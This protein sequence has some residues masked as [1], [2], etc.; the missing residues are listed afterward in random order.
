MFT[1][2]AVVHASQ[3]MTSLTLN[4]NT[5][6]SPNQNLIHQSQQQL[7]KQQQQDKYNFHYHHHH[8]SPHHSSSSQ[9]NTQQQQHHSHQHN[10]NY[11][12]QNKQVHTLPSS[13]PTSME[14]S[15]SRRNSII[16]HCSCGLTFKV[17]KNTNNIITSSTS[18]LTLNTIYNENPTLIDQINNQGS[19]TQ[20]Q[21]ILQDAKHHQKH[22]QQQSQQQHQSFNKHNYH[23]QQH[24]AHH[25]HHYQ[26]PSSGGTV[27][28]ATA[29]VTIPRYKPSEP[30]EI[31]T[32]EYFSQ[33][34]QSQDHTTTITNT[35]ASSAASINASFTTPHSHG[36]R[37]SHVHAQ[38]DFSYGQR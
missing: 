6:Q 17:D 3:S 28:V 23:Q 15:I 9:Q 20:S 16:E 10:H 12:R 8:H 11:H 5:T 37:H 13:L 25:C 33:E 26:T 19:L 29:P 21:N 4:T 18:L 32:H 22:R 30:P 31:H 1:E 36:C 2:Q 35:T 34:S 14:S 7:P 24:H 38:T 27:T